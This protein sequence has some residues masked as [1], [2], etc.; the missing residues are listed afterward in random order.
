MDK[1]ELKKVPAH[2]G[3]Q[4]CYFDTHFGCELD[5]YIEEHGLPLPPKETWEC[6]GEDSYIFVPI[7][8]AE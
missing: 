8:E 7:K 6:S 3:C 1:P 4:G 2:C 5:V